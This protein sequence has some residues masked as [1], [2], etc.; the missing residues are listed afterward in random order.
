MP[1]ASDC[2]SS[3]GTLIITYEIIKSKHSDFSM[4]C[5]Y[6]F[7]APISSRISMLL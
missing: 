7:T 6:H 3:L 5:V 4:P 1:Q 2:V